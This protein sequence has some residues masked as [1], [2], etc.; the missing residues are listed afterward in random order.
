VKE[1]KYYDRRNE[2]KHEKRQN[3]MEN[4]KKWKRNMK[5]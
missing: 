1:K 5:R 4:K 2:G 3:G